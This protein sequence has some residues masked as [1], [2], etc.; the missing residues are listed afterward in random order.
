MPRKKQV[1]AHKTNESI[2]GPKVRIGFTY[3]R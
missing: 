3:G 2:D 1:A